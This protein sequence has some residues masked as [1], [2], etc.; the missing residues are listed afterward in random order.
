MAITPRSYFTLA[1]GFFK[2]NNVL[3][4]ALMQ[5]L[6]AMYNVITLN[7]RLK[8]LKYRFMLEH[9][10]LQRVEQTLSTFDSREV[11]GQKMNRR[12]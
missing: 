12:Y 10:K 1:I 9:Q 3:E 2:R 4:S 8:I 11:L 6:Q 5:L 7:S